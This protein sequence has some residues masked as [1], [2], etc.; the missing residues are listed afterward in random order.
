MSALLSRFCRSVLGDCRSI[1]MC[2]AVSIRR[3][4]PVLPFQGVPRVP[5]SPEPIGGRSAEHNTGE[6]IPFHHGPHPSCI[7]FCETATYLRVTSYRPPQTTHGIMIAIKSRISIRLL[8]L[9]PS[10]ASL[11]T[12]QRNPAGASNG[13]AREN[14]QHLA[15]SSCV[16]SVRQAPPFK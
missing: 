9:F 10:L 8:P 15:D 4:P 6:G 2:R 13:Q 11:A 1:T 16:T 14:Q 5:E 12:S 7:I 3:L